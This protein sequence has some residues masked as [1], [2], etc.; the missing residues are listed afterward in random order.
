M[1]LLSKIVIT[2][3]TLGSSIGVFYS[4]PA[5]AAN[6]PATPGGVRTGSAP[7]ATPSG[8]S[9][10]CPSGKWGISGTTKFTIRCDNLQNFIGDFYKVLI[11]VAGSVAVLQIIK[12]GYRVMLVETGEVGSIKD[13]KR[14]ATSVATGLL[15]IFGIGLIVWVMSQLIGIPLVGH[16]P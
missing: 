5:Y 7:L 11:A 8:G 13:A 10:Y 6:E 16:N 9:S 14:E 4:S 3:F 1:P 15:L 2:I 12:I